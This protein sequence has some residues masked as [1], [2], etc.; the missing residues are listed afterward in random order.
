MAASGVWMD[1][2]KAS[3]VLNELTRSRDPQLLTQIESQAWAPLLEMAR[4]RDMGHASIPRLILGRIRGI[5]EERL[6]PLALG[7]PE[8]FLGAIGTR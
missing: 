4:W 2:N 7:A 8:A 5:P 3:M 1:R 6:T